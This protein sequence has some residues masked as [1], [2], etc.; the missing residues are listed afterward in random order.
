M[1]LM[2]SFESWKIR[3]QWPDQR[4]APVMS[5]ELPTSSLKGLDFFTQVFASRFQLFPVLVNE[6]QLSEFTGDVRMPFGRL[7]GQFVLDV[8]VGVQK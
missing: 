1:V 6:F 4:Q 7:P 2:L 5:A 8:D 3:R